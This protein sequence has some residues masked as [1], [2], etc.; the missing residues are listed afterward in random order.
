MKATNRIL[1]SVWTLT[2]TTINNH[3]IEILNYNRDDSEGYEKESELP[4]CVLIENEKREV[5][6]VKI[7]EDGIITIYEVNNPK[8]IF[9]YHLEA[10]KKCAEAIREALAK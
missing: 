4:K 5:I 3:T 1:D 7:L 2:Y 6:F 10:E 9:S 8:H